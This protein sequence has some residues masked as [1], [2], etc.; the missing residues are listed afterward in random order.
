MP[1]KRNI[2]GHKPTFRSNLEIEI[3]FRLKELNNPRKPLEPQTLSSRP[4]RDKAQAHRG[5]FHSLMQ[6]IQLILTPNRHNCLVEGNRESMFI[7]MKS[8]ESW[9]IKR[10]LPDKRPTLASFL[11]AERPLEMED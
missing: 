9:V 11:K 6:E 2:L 4:S 3:K 8:I 7:R 10:L 1:V 5:I